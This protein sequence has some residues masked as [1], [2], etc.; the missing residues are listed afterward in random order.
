[1]ARSTEAHTGFVTLFSAA[2]MVA[3]AFMAAD[4]AVYVS[5][6]ET[7][8]G[9]IESVADIAYEGKGFAVVIS[10]ADAEGTLRTFTAHTRRTL[11]WGE[12]YQVGASIPVLYDPT[13]PEGAAQINRFFRVWLWPTLCFGAGLLFFLF[14]KPLAEQARKQSEAKRRAMTAR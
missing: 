2:L 5:S 8:Q 12:S 11:S 6:A 4:K 10:F 13:D 1:M 14:R 7:A 3:G 9:T